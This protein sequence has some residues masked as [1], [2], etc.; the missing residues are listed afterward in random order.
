[1]DQRLSCGVVTSAVKGPLRPREGALAASKHISAAFSAA[2]DEAER[3]HTTQ[4]LVPT[5]W[6]RVFRL[7]PESAAARTVLMHDFHSSF[8][9]ILF[10]GREM[11]LFVFEALL[12]C[13]VDSAVRNGAV[14][15]F[16]VL[17]CWLVLRAVRLHFGQNNLSN[18]TLVDRHFLI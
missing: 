15:A 1:M 6:Q 17:M 7:P 14:T 5:Y 9:S 16:V 11:R 3:N 2:L 8:A 18:K 13:A 12:F 4:V 10:F